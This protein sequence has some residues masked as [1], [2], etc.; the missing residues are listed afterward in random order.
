MHYISY[1]I[2]GTGLVVMWEDSRSRGCGFKSHQHKQDAHFFTFICCKN[3]DSLFEK[4]ENIQKVAVDGP[5][6]FKTDDTINY[7]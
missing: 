7:C 1:L 5:F 3:C 2:D 4:T 6:I